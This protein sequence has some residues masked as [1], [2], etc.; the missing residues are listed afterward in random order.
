MALSKYLAKIPEVKKKCERCK[1]EFLTRKKNKVYCTPKCN[2]R[3]NEE[4]E[5]G[6]RA[7]RLY[8]KKGF[9][10][11]CK[12]EFKPGASRRYRYCSPQCAKL[13]GYERAIAKY[14]M[15]IQKGNT[16]P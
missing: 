1:V 13:A 10:G 5:A 12:Q 3:H 14:Q 15:L 11:H 9:C 7:Y 6:K 4:K 16:A 8:I 2:K